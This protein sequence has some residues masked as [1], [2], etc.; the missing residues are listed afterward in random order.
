VRRGLKKDLYQSDSV[1]GLLRC[2][3]RL[4]PLRENQ[5]GRALPPAVP[6]Y[7][8]ARQV[9]SIIRVA[10][11]EWAAAARAAPEVGADAK[12]VLEE[13]VG[14]LNLEPYHQQRKNRHQ[15]R[16]NRVEIL[17]NVVEAA[18]LAPERGKIDG[19]DQGAQAFAGYL[20]E[21]KNIGDEKVLKQMR[22][23][24]FLRELR[25]GVNSKRFNAALMKAADQLQELSDDE[26]PVALRSI[27]EFKPEEFIE[28]LHRLDSI[29]QRAR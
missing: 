9:A 8:S 16:K 19:F 20:R 26:L 13:L 28:R 14:Q 18:V 1:L 29:L 3:C 17:V 23:N 5:K 4:Y 24:A 2:L 7:E 27:T 12:K 21:G 11:Q 10:Y 15:Q 6:D 22:H 25:D